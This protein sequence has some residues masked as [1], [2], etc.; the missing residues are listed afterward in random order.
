MSLQSTKDHLIQLLD[1]QDNKVIALSGKWGTGKSHLWRD[2][3]GGS[4][5]QKVQAALYVSLFGLA[6]MDQVKLKIIQSSI[7]VAGE[8]SVWWD[9]AKKGWSAASK[10]LE[11]VN[12]G[13]GAINEI[14]LLAVPAFL[15]ERVIVLDDIE[16]KHANLSV[17]E[18]MGFIDEYTQQHGARIVMILNNDKLADKVLW[19]TLREKVIDQELRLDTTSAEAFEIAVRIVPTQYADRIGKAIE[20][21]GVTNI[22]IIC[23][24]IKA[25]NRI[26][27]NRKGLSEE[28]LARVVPSTVLLAATHYKGLENGPDFEFILK[29]AN[30]DAWGDYGKNEEELDEAGKQRAGWRLMLHK[31]GI[32]GCDEYENIVVDFL[33]SGLFDSAD[34]EKIISR[35]ISEA[36]VMHAVTLARKLHEHAVWH[37]RMTDAE[38]TAEAEEVVKHAHLLDPYTVTSQHQLI[39]ELTDGQPIA[40]QLVKNW[41]DTFKAKNLENFEYENFWNQPIHPDIE[42]AFDATKAKSQ[43]K[44]SVFDACKHIAENSGWGSK[45]EAILKASTVQDFE[46]MIRTLEVEDLRLFMCKFLDMCIHSGT[47]KEHFGPAIDHFVEACKNIYNDHSVPRL[48][49]LIENLFE[50]SKLKSRLIPPAE[51]PAV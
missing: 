11:S 40:D 5:D 48:G 12:K 4:Q 9:R 28:V 1:D 24:V 46:S 13:F 2:V 35:Y 37:H 25:V 51:A 45:Q 30:P 18:V 36:D 10:V 6:S 27:G 49:K 20:V 47:Y 38:L 39:S 34:V 31:I 21:C 50:S 43:A 16:R 8:S 44:S 22:R 14:A 19:D 23:K 15:K 41:I 17:D 32:V 7:P 33:K 29:I 3:K 42:A 26:L